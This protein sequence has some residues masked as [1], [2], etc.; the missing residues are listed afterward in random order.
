MKS[1]N[2]SLPFSGSLSVCVEAKSEIDAIA[3]AKIA[4]EK[5]SDGDIVDCAQFGHYEVLTS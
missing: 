5:M 3:L 2:V 4:F 1:F